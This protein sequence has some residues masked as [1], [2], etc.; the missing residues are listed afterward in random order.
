MTETIEVQQTKTTTKPRNSFIAFALSLLL[1]GLGQVY[2]GQPKKAIF[3]WGLRLFFPFLFGLTLGLTFFYELL[4][5]L[6][7]IMALRIYIIVDGVKNAKRQREYVLKPYN[8]WY[9]YLLIAT[10]MIAVFTV[11]DIYTILGIRT[12]KI[13]TSSNS[14]TLQIGDRLVAD[15][16]VYKNSEPDYGDIVIFSEPDGQMYVFR[17]V[18]RPNDEIDLIDNIVSINNKPS[19]ATFIK[20]TTSDKI[21][22][23][24][25]EEELPNGHKHLIY[26]FKQA[27]NNAKANINNIVVPPDSYY[28]LGD[29]RDTAQDS[30]YNGFVTRDKIV[31]RI[32]YSWWGRTGTKRM[33][34]DFR[35]Q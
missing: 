10:G 28:L 1:P 12:F 13:P 20:E 14:P 19:K 30:R 34:I 31:G 7:I 8:T 5:L 6:V 32:I 25:F 2:N 17:V 21:P 15:M 9:Y 23:V 24:E 16:R 4:V 11:Y 3:F 26:K 22:V 18:G 27:H 29:N 35:D 33:N